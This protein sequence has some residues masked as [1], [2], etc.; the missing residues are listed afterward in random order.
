MLTRCSTFDSQVHV[1]PH[2]RSSAP[3]CSQRPPADRRPPRR[4]RAPSHRRPP[5]RHPPPRRHRPPR[6]PRRSPPKPSHAAPRA[7]APQ[8]AGEGATLAACA[9]HIEPRA[10]WTRT[11]ESARGGAGPAA[12][13]RGQGIRPF[14]TSRRAI[15]ALGALLEARRAAPDLAAT[16]LRTL[17]SSQ[18]RCVAPEIR[19]CA[20]AGAKANTSWVHPGKVS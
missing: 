1:A 8:L 12:A 10:A 5:R 4:G 13:P 18:S 3:K 16:S 17:T 7:C 15:T 19:A 9:E 11:Q 14:R 2:P 6:A 20:R